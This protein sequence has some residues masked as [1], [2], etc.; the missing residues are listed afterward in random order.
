MYFL[1]WGF[2]GKKKR[3]CSNAAGIRQRS[4]WAAPGD[5]LK[6][7][8]RPEGARDRRRRRRTNT[9]L[10]GG[11]RKKT[12]PGGWRLSRP[13]R[14]PSLGGRG[15]FGPKG[16]GTVAGAREPPVRGAASPKPRRGA[17]TSANIARQRRSLKAPHFPSSSFDSLRPST[18]EEQARSGLRRDKPTQGFKIVEAVRWAVSVKALLVSIRVMMRPDPSAKT[19]CR[20]A[21]AW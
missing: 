21:G 5:K 17:G 19:T 10:G 9:A 16:R 13:S 11:P 18:G 20:L 8:A 1:S 6:R 7:T 12:R 2:V 14:P 4:T 15:P 3:D